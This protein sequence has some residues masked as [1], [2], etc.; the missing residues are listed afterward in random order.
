MSSLE[1]SSL[2]QLTSARFRLFLREPEALF[3]TFAF[4]ILL[5]VGLGIAFRNRPP[6]VLPVAA[7]TPQLTQALAA[8]PGLRASTVDE[9]TGTHAL[10]T[11]NIELLAVQTPAGVDFKYDDTNPDGRL[12]RLLA[13]R[14][15][16]SAAGL[17]EPVATRNDLVHEAGARYIDFVIPGLLGM[18]LIGSG[19]WG[20]GFPIVEARQKKLLKRLVASPMPRWQYLASF[21]ISRLLLLVIEV[22][23]FLGFAKLT[24]GVPFRGSLLQLGFLC[25][26]AA[27]AF[28]CLGLLIASRARTMEAVSG[29]MNLAMLPMWI[30]SGIFFSASRFPAILQP[31]V[32][33]LPLT[34]ANDAF[35]A[36]MLQGIG[37]A[38]LTAPIAILLAW[39]VIPFA[40]SLRIFRWR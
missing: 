7:T 20:L 16:Q 27:L 37:I 19:I 5:A 24:F 17:H 9:A 30:L 6:D 4:P 25:V 1:S 40:V 12:A 2:Y 14:D 3:W 10:A 34:A 29:L 32:R 38:H 21:L 35:R 11:G 39:L 36:N 18:N 13:N 15:L 8:D 22:L 26:L 33:A 23:V 31:F 28:S